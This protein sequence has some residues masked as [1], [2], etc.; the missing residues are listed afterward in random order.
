MIRFAVVGLLYAAALVAGPSVAQ[1]E[2]QTMWNC[3]DR[4][5]KP[6]L[7][8]QKEDTVGKECRIV[9][10]SRVTVVPAAQIPAASTKPATKSTASAPSPAGFPKETAVDRSKGR[11]KQR[12][13]LEGEVVQEEQLLAQAKREL[14]QQEATRGGDERN[15]AKVLERLQKYRDNVE[16]HEKNIEALKR[17][18]ANLYR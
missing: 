11:E 10:Q 4:E 8:N 17:E 5:G 12:Q 7:T 9:T 16:V 3:K 6:L 13:T 14:A 15:Y 2:L 18:L 1:S